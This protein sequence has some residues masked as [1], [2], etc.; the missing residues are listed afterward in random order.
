MNNLSTMNGYLW[1]QGYLRKK[2]KMRLWNQQK[3]VSRRLT[4]LPTYRQ[5][6]RV[7]SPIDH[8]TCL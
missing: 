3:K 2:K 5:N 4:H 6:E 8:G 7:P 1:K